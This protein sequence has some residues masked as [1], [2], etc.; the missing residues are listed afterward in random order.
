[1]SW[2]AELRFGL[3]AVRQATRACRAV[4]GAIDPGKLDKQDKS[5]VTVADFASQ[6]IVCRALAAAFPQDGM[7]AEEDAHD[8]RKPENAPFLDRILAEVRA[9]GIDASLDE[10][11]GWIDHGR[12]RAGVTRRWT[13]DPIDGTKGFLRKE[14]Y[15]ISLALLVDGVIQVAILGCPNLPG[16]NPA[17]RRAGGLFSAIR[18]AGAWR[19]SLDD[20]SMGPQQVRVNETR[21]SARARLC[22]SVEAAH[23]AHG[24][25]AEI[26]KLLHITGEPAR[27]DSQA[28]YAV[29]ARGEADIYL[30]LPTRADYREKIW[31]HAGGVL[32]VEEAGG[33]VS[34]IHGQP[35]DFS[36]GATLAENQ[37]VVVTNGRLHDQVL[38]AVEAVL[39][40]ASPQSRVQ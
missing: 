4:Q 24:P 15:A 26:A 9:T 11:S 28:K 21:E 32:V 16:T 33:R 30:R 38:R 29:V 17:E 25:S 31:D 20:F 6:A 35:L 2:E 1:M 3:E 37:G 12:D 36:R 34:D 5:P 13:L 7:I 40:P 14:Q 19:W 10:I 22:E 23:S 8:L 39:G 27:L 18:G